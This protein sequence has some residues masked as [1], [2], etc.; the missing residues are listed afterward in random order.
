MSWCRGILSAL[1]K[2]RK[3]NRMNKKKTGNRLL[4]AAVI[5]AFVLLMGSRG[6]I[7]FMATVVFREGG[8][9]QYSPDLQ[10]SF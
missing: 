4:I 7:A 3:G 5:A 6:F 10:T 1:T 9:G 8:Y 2:P